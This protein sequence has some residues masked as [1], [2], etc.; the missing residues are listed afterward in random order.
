MEFTPHKLSDWIKNRQS[1][2]VSGLKEGSTI[3]DSV[4]E[5]LLENAC[6]APS[7]GLVQA[8][9]F[10]VFAGEAVK[11][12]FSVQQEIYKQITPPEK[13]FDFKYK[14]YS[15]KWKRVSHIVTIV[16]K[17]DPFK[18]FPKQEDIVSV[19]CAIE[20]IYLSL[21]AFGI[22][23]YL[24]TG[25]ICYS[26]EMRDFLKLEDEDTLMGFFVLGEPNESFQ[27]PPRTRIAAA[28]KTEWIRE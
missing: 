16:A 21:D 8:W 3:D 19:A 27:R 14:A 1:T 18:R 7:H 25:D 9:H 23:G 5:K 10:K 22:G 2:F 17:R 12:F 4:I 11:R 24:S 26:N 6:W 13:F 20:N 15:E 28:D